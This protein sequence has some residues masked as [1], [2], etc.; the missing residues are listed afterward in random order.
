MNKEL[1]YSNEKSSDKSRSECVMAGFIA[2]ALLSV[3]W[4]TLSIAGMI[5]VYQYRYVLLTTPEFIMQ[6]MFIGLMSI[7]GFITTVEWILKCVLKPFRKK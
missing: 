3:M 7:V 1:P 4:L 2:I 5:G 6:F